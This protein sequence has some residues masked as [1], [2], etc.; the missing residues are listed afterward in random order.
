ML[1][2]KQFILTEEVKDLGW[3]KKRYKHH[4]AD[5]THTHNAEVHGHHVGVS[6]D[7]EGTRPGHADISFTVNHSSTMRRQDY[8]PH[9]ALAVM[10]HVRNSAKTFIKNNPHIKTIGWTPMDSDT[11]PA[12]ERKREAAKGRIYKSL[13]RGIKVKSNKMGGAVAQVGT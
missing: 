12:N 7:L 6:Y 5:W 11:D 9:H 4:P 1:S 3:K 10:R 13:A 8:P 2:F